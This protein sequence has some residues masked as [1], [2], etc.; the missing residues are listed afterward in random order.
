MSMRRIYQWLFRH[1]PMVL[2]ALAAALAA[3]IAL[4]TR[5]GMRE[6]ILEMLP[7][8]NPEIAEFKRAR[9][10][11]DAIGSLIVSIGPRRDDDA[12]VTAERLISA[13]D[14]L[15]LAMRGSNLFNEV[16]DRRNASDYA[17]VLDWLRAR[18]AALF[19]EEDRAWLAAQS[20]P[21]AMTR[22]LAGWRRLLMTNPAPYMARSL[23]Q[24]PF[25]Y[26]GRLAARF[27]RAIPFRDA[28][29]I[30]DG[31]V[32]TPDGRRLML[33]AT[34]RWP[35]TDSL[36][37][38]ALVRFM[39]GEAKRLEA[40]DKNLTAAWISGQRFS[41][42]NADWIKRDVKATLILATIA[43]ALC[44]VMVY[45][46]PWLVALTFAPTVLG[47]VLAVGAIA[48]AR[49]K[50][51]GISIGFGSALVGITVDLGVY[52]LFHIDRIDRTLER[53]V[54][55][56]KM[57]E[58]TRPILM[59]AATTM[60]AFV[61]L[62]F[63]DLPGYRDLG[64]FSLDGYAM[65]TVIALFLLPLI[66]PRLKKSARPQT[67]LRLDR[68]FM[69]YLDLLSRHRRALAIVVIFITLICAC[70]LTKLGFEGDYR[71]LGATTPE[72]ARDLAAIQKTFGTVMSTS[73][74]AARGKTADEALR[75][76]EKVWGA[77]LDAEKNGEIASMHSIAPVLPSHETQRENI[78]RWRG[79]WTAETIARVRGQLAAA[80]N[81]ARIRPETF[82]PFFNALA[83]DPPAIDLKTATDGLPKEL[84]EADILPPT[85][86]DPNW[87]VLSGVRAAHG[88]EPIEARLRAA[89]VEAR[90]HDEAHFMRSMVSF[91]QGQMG[92]VAWVSAALFLAALLAFERD[93][94][95]LAR[96]IAPVAACFVW[97]FGTLGWLGV[98]VD[99]VNSLVIV[100]LFGVV[101]DYA[102]FL[103]W[104]LETWRRGNAAF[105]ATSGIVVALSAISTTIGFA[106]MIVARHPALRSIGI[107]TFT[108]MLTGLAAVY[109]IVPLMESTR[110]RSRSRQARRS[111]HE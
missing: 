7:A 88:F 18:R 33:Q 57:L 11:R 106:A 12:S 91:I 42:V 68:L 77:L 47:G 43:I 72:I 90:V 13:S 69:R 98:R 83:A 63:S 87:L 79:F 44:V 107:V 35:A 62:I 99:L 15:A 100:I 45:R 25:G 108:G 52:V 96:L 110:Q 29:S 21:E 24:D 93:P 5:L 86:D 84:L 48:L 74:V 41:L 28:V 75:Q 97:C 6:D 95:R 89:G 85:P 59:C 49:G 46:R 105:P 50:I 37:A 66:V 80:A 26:D 32:F 61:A 19:S 20:T 103:S 54:V 17:G 56:G 39:D 65:G 38:P 71:K 76:S 101:V 92:R 2:V 67:W 36:H 27:Q 64:L 30:R 8:G 73:S 55:I 10:G 1:R 34:P 22:T 78:A 23:Y 60:T 70:G 53:R 104:G 9:L 82:D 40:E 111:D 81:G 109:L 102:I 51:S 4:S 16:I 14:K 94:R 31:R 58:L 3:S